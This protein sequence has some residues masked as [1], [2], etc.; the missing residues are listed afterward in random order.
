MLSPN[1]ELNNLRASMM[2]RLDEQPS[3]SPKPLHTT[4][5]FSLQ[6]NQEM[7]CGGELRNSATAQTYIFV[8]CGRRRDKTVEF[9][10]RRFPDHL[11]KD[12]C[13]IICVDK[14]RR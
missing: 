11:M 8:T 7:G 3:E 10:V 2:L 4:D 9:L 5:F 6:G 13:A 14:I 1:S 12:A